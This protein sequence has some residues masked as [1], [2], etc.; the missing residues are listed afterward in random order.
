[1]ILVIR[2]DEIGGK[3]ATLAVGIGVADYREV[4]MLMTEA[5]SVWDVVCP[6]AHRSCDDEEWVAT[7]RFVF[8]YRGIYVHHVGRVESV[9]DP[10]QV[11]FINADETYR[12]SHPLGGGDSTLAI[13][14]ST[15]T[16]MEIVPVE[17]L[18]LN[19]SAALNLSS[20]RIEV[21][22]HAL[23]AVLRHRLA[24]GTISALEAEALSLTLVRRALGRRSS[25]GT[26]ITARTRSLVDGAKV[27]IAADL[28]R[29]KTLSEVAGE[30][31]V[32]PVYLTQIFQRVE[33]IPLYRYQLQQRLALA[34]QMLGQY[35][36]VTEL[37]F[38]LGFSSHSHF[39]AAFK[40]AFGQTPSAF[41]RTSLLR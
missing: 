30:V 40:Q 23:A 11:V 3:Q 16:L 19:Q 18:R 41:R 9:A 21:Q 25:R 31:G 35:D 37:A 5:L 38:T 36:D 24:R 29:R 28:G 2:V 33:G 13:A 1:M 10:S 20:V 7:T 6:G 15:P 27:V 34:L 22:T 8:P 39:S 32:S 12:V 17:L 4:A 26:S 14:L